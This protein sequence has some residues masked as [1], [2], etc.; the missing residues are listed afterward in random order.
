[1]VNKHRR[2]QQG[3]SPISGDTGNTLIEENDIRREWTNYY[4]KLYS[5]ETDPV[6][7]HGNARYI[8]EQLE[9][10]NQS[11][12]GYSELEK[13]PIQS[14]ETLDVIR[15]MKNNKASGWD[16]IVTEN[17]RYSGDVTISAITWIMN[18]IIHREKLPQHYKR[19]L[20]VPIPKVNKDR[21]IKDNNRGITLL[22]TFYK[23]LERV[24]GLVFPKECYWW[25]TRRWEETLLESTYI[26]VIT[27]DGCL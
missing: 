25:T 13:G 1:M 7:Y 5:W 17:I 6:R 10:I 20:I 24:E 11:S 12:S 22:T 14:K 9:Y 15:T 18:A 21:V 19:G 4:T 8:E 2:T 27:R 3:T 23:I 26:Y 16:T